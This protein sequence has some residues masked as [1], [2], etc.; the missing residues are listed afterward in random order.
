[1][2]SDVV[3]GYKLQTIN[4]RSTLGYKFVVFGQVLKRHTIRKKIYALIQNKSLTSVEGALM[5]DTTAPRLSAAPSQ[6][7]GLLGVG[8]GSGGG[9]IIFAG[10]GDAT[11]VNCFGERLTGLFFD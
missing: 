3:L 2:Q 4:Y 5:P 9:D 6:L 11:T 8:V 7:G 10:R 1:M